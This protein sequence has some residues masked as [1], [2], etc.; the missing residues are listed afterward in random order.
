MKT[1]KDY[2]YRSIAKDNSCLSGL[3]R[4]VLLNVLTFPLPFRFRSMEEEKLIL[5]KARIL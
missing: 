1:Q 5:L 2:A 4:F 3:L